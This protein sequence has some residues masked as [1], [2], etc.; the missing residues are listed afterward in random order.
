MLKEERH[1]N[2][3]AILRRE[4]KLVA[5]EL[6]DALQI[7]E[8]TVRRDLNEMAASNLL[9]RVHGG[10]LPKA[11]TEISYRYRERESN[12]AKAAIAAKCMSLLQPGQIIVIDSGTTALRVAQELPQDFAATVLT[13]SLPVL[14]TLSSYARI[15]VIGVG[16]KLFKEARCLIGPQ[17]VDGIRAVYAD[18][19]ILGLNGIHPELGLGVLD[20]E[21]VSL[22]TAMLRCARQVVAVA[23]SD[24][25]GTVGSFLFGKVTSLTHLVTD[26]AV[27]EE[28]LAPYRAAGIVV[29]TD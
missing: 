15:D 18:V 17:A 19:C 22:K 20:Y 24:K 13:N 10:A 6:S 14:E 12:S 5:S 2:I 7:S 8:D 16:G 21:S 9:H 26:S 29:L 25:I 27:S 3:L 1:K 11:P 23:A 28:M 4:G